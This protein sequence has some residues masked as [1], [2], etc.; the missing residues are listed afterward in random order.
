MIGA[1][2]AVQSM[3]KYQP[4]THS[5]APFVPHARTFCILSRAES[6]CLTLANSSAKQSLILHTFDGSFVQVIPNFPMD[7]TVISASLAPT[8][9][10]AYG[11]LNVNCLFLSPS[12][13]LSFAFSSQMSTP[14]F[15][16]SQRLQFDR[17]W[18]QLTRRGLFYR[19]IAVPMK[20]GFFTAL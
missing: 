8:G 6:H 20:S 11:S 1:I 7:Q 2:K 17:L 3:F 10:R 19:W 16:P 18:R 12:A 4:I 5:L 14:S 13:F 9:T 15:S